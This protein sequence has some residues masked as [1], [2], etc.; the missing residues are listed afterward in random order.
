MAMTLNG[1]DLSTVTSAMG[2]L[3][4]TVDA[5]NAPDLYLSTDSRLSHLLEFRVAMWID[6]IYVPICAGLGIL[7]NML[8]FCVLLSPRLSGSSTSVYMAALSVSDSL[9]QVVNILF[10]VRKFPGHETLR[11]GTCGLVYF[12]LYFSIHYNVIVMMGMTLERYLAIRFPLKASGWCTPRRARTTVVVMCVIVVAVNFHNLI[13]RKMV[14]N[15]V[16]KTEVCAPDGPTNEFFLFK[17]W[18]WIDGAVYCYIPLLTV[19]VLNVLIVLQMR[20]AQKF[21][22]TSGSAEQSA[23]DV[24]RQVTVML[25]LVTCTFLLLVGPM[26][27]LIV[28]ERYVWFRTTIHEQAVFHLVRTIL[29]NVAYTNHAINFCLYCLSGNRFRQE[30]ARLFLPCVTK[31]KQHKS[32]QVLSIENNNTI[33]TTLPG[34]KP[35]IA[36]ISGGNCK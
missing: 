26:S 18:P 15:D 21:R 9:V 4:S 2:L 6:F 32:K 14:W 7:G 10:L 16:L 35:S 29:N 36:S 11:H 20:S 25:L 22:G 30:F 1:S 5:E 34:C 28:V 3:V 33:T 31:G 12:L 23:S 24:S 8:S 13:L 27:I 17:V 19:S